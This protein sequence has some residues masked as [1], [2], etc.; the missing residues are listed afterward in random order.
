MSS[1]R[2][3]ESTLPFYPPEGTDGARDPDHF[4]FAVYSLLSQ[5]DAGRES[6][7]NDLN[8]GDMANGQCCLA[9]SPDFAGKT[10]RDVYDYHI[11]AAKDNDNTIHPHFFIVADQED[12]N[13]SG[14]LVVYLLAD[15]TLNKD[16][17]EYEDEYVVGVGR[18]SVDDADCAGVNLDISK[19]SWIEF[20][21]S[22]HRD[23]WDDDEPYTNPRYSKY[24]FET[25]EE[26]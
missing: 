14:V 5:D 12:W 17:D 26:N 19:L 8:N 21:D 13:E 24:H 22:W 11:E 15:R 7:L 4:E 20:K 25:G 3:L 6:L 18:C 10:L 9:P 16:E 1:T 23:G 2:E